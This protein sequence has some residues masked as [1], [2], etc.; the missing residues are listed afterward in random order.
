MTGTS[1]FTIAGMLWGVAAIGIWLASLRSSS[2]V[3]T[4]VA[5][6][7]T[8]AAL[9]TGVLGALVTQ[10][11]SRASWLGFAIFGWVSLIL[12]EWDWIGGP[13][14]H[15]LTAALGAMAEYLLPE[16]ATKSLLPTALPRGR[17]T[18]APNAAYLEEIQQRSIK[19]GNFVQIGRMT[20]SLLFGL[21]GG[22][23]GQI[24][25]ARSDETTQ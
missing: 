4:T 1:R 14:G 18:F 21:I 23:I 17:V 25:V 9:L 10:R 6:T 3:W 8:L 22:R 16:P 11:P 5:A 15:D 24:L 7:M 12:V 20:L 19:L 13:L 2:T